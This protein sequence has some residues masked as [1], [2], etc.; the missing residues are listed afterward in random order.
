MVRRVIIAGGAKMTGKCVNGGPLMSHYNTH[1][2][3]ENIMNKSVSKTPYRWSGKFIQ[4]LNPD[5]VSKSR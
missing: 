2:M 5:D 4:F 1:T 3:A